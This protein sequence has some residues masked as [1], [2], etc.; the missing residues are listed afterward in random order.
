MATNR[1]AYVDGLRA[2]AALYVVADHIGLTVWPHGGAPAVFAYGH[3]AVSVFIVLSGFSLMRANYHGA[4]DFY[5]RR[6]RR[7]L[8][9]YYAALGLSLALIWLAIGHPTGSWWDHSLPVTW[10]GVVTHALLLQDLSPTNDQTINYVFWSIAL[11]CHIYLL[12]PA[13]VKLFR[14]YHP[15]FAAGVVMALALALTN[16]LAVTALGRIPGYGQYAVAP[17]FVGLFAAGMCAA[18]LSVKRSRYANGWIAALGWL[19]VALGASRVAVPLLDV[20]V[21]VAT[22]ATLLAAPKWLSWRPLA[23]V[24]GFSY[25]LYLIHAPLVQLAWQYAVRPLGW[26]DMAAYAVMLAV[27]SPLIVVCAW[28]FWWCCERPFM[29]RS[30]AVL[31]SDIVGSGTLAPVGNTDFQEAAGLSPAWLPVRHPQHRGDGVA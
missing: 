28:G 13:L 30:I 22:V 15:L 31:R 5:A 9:P 11:E 1:L 17:Q 19:A 26:G 4:L 7:I 6:A 27:G 25:S 24:G 12:F 8:P 18:A 14:R 16:A 29:T 2:L 20:V 10:R 3:Y 23:W 21:G